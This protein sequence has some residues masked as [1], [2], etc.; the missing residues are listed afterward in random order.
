[1]CSAIL[2]DVVRSVASAEKEKISC[3]NIKTKLGLVLSGDADGEHEGLDSD[4]NGR[5]CRDEFEGLLCKPAAAKLIQSVGVDVVELVDDAAFIFSGDKNTIGFSDFMNIVLQLRG[6]N[7]T[8]V[9]DLMRLR[10]VVN[11]NIHN[12]E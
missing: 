11:T 6:T 8:T 10:Q 7:N 9:K 5:I 4:G 3:Q 1:M 12:S 2:V